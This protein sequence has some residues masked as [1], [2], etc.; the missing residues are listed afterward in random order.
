MQRFKIPSRLAAFL[1]ISTMLTGCGVNKQK[2]EQAVSEL[3]AAKEEL[4]DINSQMDAAPQKQADLEA[5]I[6]SNK[7][8]V[9]AL[10]SQQEELKQQGAALDERIKKLQT[11]EAFVFQNAGAFLDAQDYQGALQGYKDFVSQFPQSP[12]VAAATSLI[13]QIEYKLG[14]SR[15]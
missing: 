13:A 11:Q 7:R 4:A 2:H 5:K 1:L 8:K 12:R 10:Q 14:S 15:P 3:A 6:K 9:A